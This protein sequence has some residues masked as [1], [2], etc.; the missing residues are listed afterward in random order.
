[1]LIELITPLVLATSPMAIIVPETA[2]YN[3]GTQMVALN[4]TKD[5]L[6]LTWNGTQTYGPTGRPTDSDN[7]N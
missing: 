5:T 4:S 7:D 2:I 3:H 6:S 1:M